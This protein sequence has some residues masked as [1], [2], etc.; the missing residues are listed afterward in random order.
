MVP[1]PARGLGDERPLVSCLVT[2]PRR[3]EQG[4]GVDAALGQV[5]L[6][7]A[8][9]DVPFGERPPRAVV[10]RHHDEGASRVIEVLVEGA[11][12]VAHGLV[13]HHQKRAVALVVLA[14]LESSLG[15]GLLQVA[16]LVGLALVGLSSKRALIEV[17][18][19]GVHPLAEQRIDAQ[20]TRP[21][22]HVE[23][24][25]EE[26]EGLLGV[27]FGVDL[28][29]PR[30]LAPEQQTHVLPPLLRVGHQARLVRQVQLVRV[31]VRKAN[32]GP[33]VHV[34]AVVPVES[35][36]AAVSRRVRPG[37]KAHVPLSYEGGSVAVAFQLL[38]HS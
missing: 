2:L 20:A 32:L 6:L 31:L 27:E 24:R 28:D 26:E 18:A 22:V 9:P 29:R 14:R 1:G 16:S 19:R 23:H 10:A 4:R 25:V 7:P 35:V 11:Q 36:E 15:I 17:L 5:G 3:P 12:Q 21:A 30:S 13:Q 34:A 38:G 8:H 33:V 37:L